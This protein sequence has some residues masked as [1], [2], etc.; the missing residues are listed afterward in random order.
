MSD[1]QNHAIVF[2][3]TG[4]IGWA[5]VNQILSNYPAAGTF[6]SVTAVSNRPVDADRTFWPKES[7]PKPNLQLV[8]GIDLKSGGLEAHLKEKVA[9]IDR[10]THVFYFVFAPHDVNHEEECKI[11]CN[12]MR[13]LASAL[14]T[15]SVN[16]K[17]FVYSGGTRGYGI[18]IPDGMFTPPLQESMADT[19]PADYAKTVAYPWFRKILTEASAGRDWTWTEVCP[20]V[21]VGFSPIG[22]NYSLALHWAQYLSL[23]AKNNGSNSEVAFP[24]NDGAYNARFTS[25]SSGILGRIAIHAALNPSM[26]GGKIVNM[27]DRAEPTTFAKAWPRIASFFGLVGVAPRESD[28]DRPSE[29]IETHKDL[30]G[31]YGRKAGVGAGR[32]QLDSAGWWLTFDRQLS[33]ERLRGVGFTE[34]Q[35]PSEGWLEAFS[36]LR[37]AGIIL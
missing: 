28:E 9:G 1:S 27:L 2:G 32:K 14:N 12:M 22:S 24:G 3:A 4:L 13:N 37:D 16:L 36:K 21:V 15:L 26:C 31:E 5:A 17:S 7:D 33:A 25:V 10:V 29:Y 35:D 30:L 11:N 20:D 23:Y 8:S 19:I 34:E 18:Y 6:A